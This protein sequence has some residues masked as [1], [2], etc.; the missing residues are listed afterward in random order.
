MNNQRKNGRPNPDQKYF[1]LVA[2][3]NAVVQG[4]E[5]YTVVAFS[6]EKVIVRVSFVRFLF[7]CFANFYARFSRFF[8]YI[9][10]L[11]F[12]FVF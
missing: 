1:Y 11:I 10:R 5:R 4:N 12:C 2:A 9:F 6:S 7:V 8:S 3:L